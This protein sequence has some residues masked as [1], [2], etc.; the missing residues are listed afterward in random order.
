M[1][2]QSKCAVLRTVRMAIRFAFEFCGK[3]HNMV[4]SMTG[5]LTNI[6][7]NPRDMMKMFEHL[8]AIMSKAKN[9]QG[10]QLAQLLGSRC[11]LS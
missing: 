11:S 5:N 10:V 8:D 1:H 6:L 3:Y 4:W 9:C 2:T 7:E